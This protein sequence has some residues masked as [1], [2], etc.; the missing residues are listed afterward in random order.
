MYVGIAREEGAGIELHH[1]HAG[2]G[3]VDDQHHRRR[4][5]NASAAARVMPAEHVVAAYEHLR[6]GQQAHQRDDR[7]DNRW[8]WEHRA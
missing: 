6:H 4:D 2:S 8:P 5:Q 7:A 1:R 3:A